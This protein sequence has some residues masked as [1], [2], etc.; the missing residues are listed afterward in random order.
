MFRS[1]DN[2]YDRKPNGNKSNVLQLTGI[3]FKNNKV[4]HKSL[5]NKFGLLKVYA[6]WCGYCTQ[7]V[8]DINFIAD[9]LKSVDFVVSALNYENSEKCKEACRNIGVKSFPSMFMIS[10][11]G[12]LENISEII[13]NRSIESILDVICKKTNEYSNNNG[14]CCKKTGNRIVCK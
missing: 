14:K 8:N 7:M 10:K 5:K 2:K 3:N 1:S 4:T 12:K 9:E 6:P 11:E 13:G